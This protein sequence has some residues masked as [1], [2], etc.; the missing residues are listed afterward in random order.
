MEHCLPRMTYASSD[1][2]PCGCSQ[3]ST[4]VTRYPTPTAGMRAIYQV[5]LTLY[6]RIMTRR[7]LPLDNGQCPSSTFGLV[8]TLISPQILT[9]LCFCTATIGADQSVWTTG[10][11]YVGNRDGLR[12]S[13]STSTCCAHS[14]S[15]H[16]ALS[17]SGVFTF[18]H[19]C[20]HQQLV[21]WTQHDIYPEYKLSIVVDQ[22]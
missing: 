17:H 6:H 3:S 1:R 12:L 20:L 4:V 7:D 15:L 8:V 19:T 13:E 2:V 21:Y 14:T 10:E 9:V 5:N 11:A 22:P 18:P 16:W